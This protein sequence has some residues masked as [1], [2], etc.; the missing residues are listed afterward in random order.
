MGG[1]AF[2]ISLAATLAPAAVPSDAL[3]LPLRAQVI[4]A[5]W[6]PAAELV[7]D[8]A[9][10]TYGR[11]WD[12]QDGSPAHIAHF[13]T[14]I[15]DH[16]VAE[17]QLSFTTGPADAAL[18]WGDFDGKL[19]R[20]R[21]EKFRWNHPAWSSGVLQ[22]RIKQGLAESRWAVTWGRTTELQYAGNKP[23]PQRFTLKG[24]GWQTVDVDL[25]RRGEHFA[26][27]LTIAT[28]TPGN[29]V[30][31]SR[32]RI[33]RPS[34]RAHFRAEIT[35]PAAPVFGAIWYT[36]QPQYVI[37]V[38]AQEVHRWHGNGC[39]WWPS[40]LEITKHL[41]PGKNALCFD[42]EL[43]DWMGREN[44]LIV[45]GVVRCADG[46]VI[47]IASDGSWRVAKSP[48]PGWMA[49]GFDASR[50]AWAR[51]HGAAADAR[52]PREITAA[53]IGGISQMWRASLEAG[54]QVIP[55]RHLGALEMSCPD[56][57]DP[58]FAID[59]PAVMELS[60]PLRRFDG[61]RYELAYRLYDSA[62]RRQVAGGRV[63]ALPDDTR[64]QRWRWSKAGLAR[65]IHA[66]YFDLAL[67]GQAE[68]TALLELAVCGPVGGRRIR[69]MSPEEGLE[70]TPVDRIDC[71]SADDAH[72]KY[73][74]EF[75]APAPSLPKPKIVDDPIAGRVLELGREFQWA[76]YRVRFPDLTRPYLLR[77][78]YPDSHPQVLG[79]C[80]DAPFKPPHY[81]TILGCGA[82]SGRESPPTNTLQTFRTLAWPKAHD[83]TITL[84]NY[85]GAGPLRIQAIEILRVD[86]ELPQLEIPHASPG[87]LFG[88]ATERGTVMLTSFGQYP[89]GWCFE[90]NMQN[91]ATT[92]TLR[93]WYVAAENLIRWLKFTGQN[94]W[95]YNA[96]QYD[97]VYY[98]TELSDRYEKSAFQNTLPLLA[99]MFEANGLKLFVGAEFM[100]ARP[101]WERSNLYTDQ[102]VAEGADTIKAVGSDGRQ[103]LHFAGAGSN[104]QHPLV[105]EAIVT[106]V[107]DMCRP[108]AAY[109]A[110]AGV[111]FMCGGYFAPA[112][113]KLHYQYDLLK[114]S[115]DDTSIGRFEAYA[116][117][118]V[119]DFGRT[120]EKFAQRRAWIE[121]HA[122]EAWIAWRAAAV[123]ELVRRCGGA[124][125]AVRSDLKCF[126]DWGDWSYGQARLQQWGQGRPYAEAAAQLGV[127]YRQLAG[128]PGTEHGQLMSQL[129]ELVQ[130]KDVI[131]GTYVAMQQSAEIR[132][133][134]PPERYS[135]YLE[136]PFCEAALKVSQ[137]VD[138]PWRT[139]GICCYSPRPVGAD[140]LAN[141]T[142]TFLAGVPQILWHGYSDCNH[143]CGGEQD[144]RA[145]A[146]SYRSIPAGVYREPAPAVAARNVIVRTNAEGTA[147]LLLNPGW[148]EVD[149]TLTL[150]GADPRL[151]HLND[152]RSY[153]GA[154]VKIR[155]AA[156]AT[157]SFRLPPAT[158]L[159]AAA[160]HVADPRPAARVRESL[161][162]LAAYWDRARR[163]PEILAGGPGQSLGR[164]TESLQ[165]LVDREDWGRA[166]L[167]IESIQYCR[168]LDWAK[169]KL[170]SRD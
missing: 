23:A 79:V 160:G 11:K 90:H 32:I 3:R 7:D 9:E 71:G 115:Y 55:P 129:G 1:A 165:N 107:R 5:P 77:I 124:A 162:A 147:M 44:F 93:H 140:Y 91:C 67:E 131:P 128:V 18:S 101:V 75:V 63:P 80:I 100:S 22:L 99:K 41:R 112:V 27:W 38:N 58:L 12:F 163:R 164:V 168:V 143:Y 156:F 83:A 49:P 138:W 85:H 74:A 39:G 144:L 43:M 69:G 25:G 157:E 141:Y 103:V 158:R 111:H 36:A 54:Y 50:W 65:G 45:G 88:Y 125:T 13:G 42:C 17:G 29:P 98:P 47:R 109:P 154:T 76:S 6:E 148:W 132:R 81:A 64:Q 48:Q 4:S 30:A 53:A 62:T 97:Q 72:A 19:S 35:L 108:L 60:A 135:I 110:F 61:K 121:K 10:T 87:R 2:F 24:T 123:T 153:R 105:E 31:I 120:R 155:L 84:I 151:L 78:T 152:D 92:A 28:E 57:P 89:A 14:G 149:C 114:N 139:G 133:P 117:L 73:Y 8:Y 167:L 33:V 137:A 94:A 170:T 119:P 102:E 59:E 66:A 169:T 40:W 15:L 113:F 46:H 145:A 126:F 21:Q 16:R 82:A 95:C 136:H 26:S 116:H 51:S 56:R 161:A 70:L 104:Y 159:V 118:K 142:R 20:H 146:L 130:G 122:L 86:N 127:D 106:M 96:H 150:S 166:W 68:E 52:F 34:E 134:F 37:A